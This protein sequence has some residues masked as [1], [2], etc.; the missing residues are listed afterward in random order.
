MSQPSTPVPG[1]QHLSTLYEITRTLNSSLDLDEVLENVMDRVI[2]VTGAERGFLMLCDDQRNELEF[3]V[4]RGMDRS[5]IESPE[6]QVSYTIVRQVAQDRVPLLT[7][8][9]Q[10]DARLGGGQSIIVLGLRSILCVPMT[11]KG[12]L[13]GLVYVDNRLQSGLFNEDHLALLAAFA[14]QA[15]AAIENARLYQ[16]A[17]EKGRME[18][19]LQLAYELQRG[20][21]PRTLPTVPGYEIAADWRAAREV[22]GDFYDCFRFDDCTLAA[23]I[24]DVSDKG[25]PAALFM[26]MT[27]SLI[28]GTVLSAREPEETLRQVN[29][30]L[31]NDSESGMFVTVYYSL[32][33]CG[34]EMIGVN[35]GHN[36]PLLVR[37]QRGTYDFLPRGGRPLGWFADLPVHAIPIQLEP[38]DVVVYYTDGLTESENSIGEPFGESR[39]V[40][41]VLAAVHRPAEDILRTITQALVAFV[42]PAPAFDDTTLMVVRYTGDPD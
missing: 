32:L 2:D 29:R 36:R 18:R 13:I 21:M 3:K 5:E 38:G 19:E 6:F 41:A 33:S 12:R 15:A 28:R 34:G 9:A 8:N 4:A 23:V 40:E 11:V 22:A 42:G 20:L 31:L 26:A 35:A 27:H 10:Y 1:H 16:V 14:D 17:V 7:D 37:T 39:L 24:A 30:V 25:A